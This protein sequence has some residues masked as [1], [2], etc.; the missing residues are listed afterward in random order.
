[1]KQTQRE[2]AYQHIR[3]KLAE[4]TL[5][6]GVR[7]SPAAL[8]REIGVSHIPVREAISQLKS[9]GLI[10]HMAHRGAFVKEPRRQDLVDLIELRTLLEC[11]A[12]AR[13]ARRISQRQLRELEERWQ[14]L[15]RLAEAFRVPPGADLRE[16][17]G[18]WLLG[19]LA[20]HMVLLR[21]AGNGHVI[22]V[23]EE[24][25][26][27]TQ[28]FGYRTDTPSAW[29]DPA[30]FGAENLRVHRDVYEAVCRHDAK[31]ARRAMAVHMHRA[32]RNMLSR[33]DWLRRQ[34]DLDSSQAGD[35]PESMRELVRGIQQ[36]KSTALPPLPGG[37]FGRKGAEGT[38]ESN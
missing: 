34:R 31:A 17:L 28:M 24:M 26:I 29:A 16:P 2:R 11:H 33:F 20:F 14:T 38:S 19:D 32:R 25:H 36:R 7:L 27:M 21:A 10:I 22:H 35:F 23:I 12:A 8:A 5:S 4:G 13:A 9:E 18:Q 37:V 6:A 1:M 15:C 30:T 3:R